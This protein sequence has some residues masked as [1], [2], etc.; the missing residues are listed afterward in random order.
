M[1]PYWRNEPH[2]LDLSFMTEGHVGQ[3]AATLVAL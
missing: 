1:N 3:V 2:I